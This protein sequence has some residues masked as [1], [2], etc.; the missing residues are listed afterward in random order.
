MQMSDIKISI[1]MPV[2]NAAKFLKETIN[3]V[4]QQSFR[5]YELIAVNDGST[6][7]SIEILRGI[8]DRRLKIIDKK[9]TG[10]GDTRNVGL[11]SAEGDYV[12][13][14][15]ADDSLSQW[16]LQHMYRVVEERN[17]DMVVCNYIPFRG[18]P[19]FEAKNITPQP[20]QSSRTLVRK[21]VLTSAWTKLIKKSTL[22]GA[23]ILF[24]K[25]MTYGEDLF[26]CW[27]A[28]LASENVWMTDEALYGYRMTDSGATMK[29][30][31]QLY[32][33]YKNAFADL[34]Q[35]SER[36]H[37]E[38]D[39]FFTTRMP[40]FILMTVREKSSIQQKKQRL[41]QI[42]RDPVIRALLQD[43]DT[44]KQEINSEEAILYQNCRDEKLN[45]LLLYG[46]KRQIRSNL[47][48][49]K[50]ILRG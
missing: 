6:D 49:M 35:F 27:K 15:D 29:Y 36:E 30:H 21:G 32:E 1:I 28:F 13:F 23:H 19:T 22:S 40:S 4:M 16:Y 26:F 44:F 48:S 41:Q 2:Y 11:K 34:K 43:W 38:M 17:A 8:N 25:N 5:D 39:V 10:V 47:S 46:Y 24:D 12:C 7:N 20:V 18:R 31:A 9:N 45:S 42:L 14:L 3:S 50:S 33:K 37:T